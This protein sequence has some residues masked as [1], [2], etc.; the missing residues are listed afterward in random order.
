MRRLGLSDV[1]PASE[2]IPCSPSRQKL[3]T[4]KARNWC[5][6]NGAAQLVRRKWRGAL[7]E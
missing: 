6:A 1:M 3:Q 2:A 5:G 4:L 7:M